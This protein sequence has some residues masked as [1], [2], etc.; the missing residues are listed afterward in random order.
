MRL[1]VITTALVG[2]VVAG[3]PAHAETSRACTGWEVRVDHRTALSVRERRLKRLIRCV[4]REVGIPSQGQ[5][6]TVIAD[7]ES[8]L[9]PW[10]YN[11]SSGASGL[12]QHL[13]SYWPGRA[14]DLPKV[15]FP[16]WPVSGVFNARANAWAAA[17]M[18]KASG[19]GAW[20]TA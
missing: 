10:A 19:W 11:T 3:A 9:A 12:F 4:F 20:T 16:R 8:G 14:H 7:R 18:V 15:E 2:T 1:A 17:Q 6:A 13:R 5:Y